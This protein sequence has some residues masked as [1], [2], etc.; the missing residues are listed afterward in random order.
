MKFKGI[1]NRERWIKRDRGWTRNGIKQEK[2]WVKKERAGE[3]RKRRR[4]EGN[5]IKE[6]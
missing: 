6:K 5:K 2:E 4:W 1:E 3:P